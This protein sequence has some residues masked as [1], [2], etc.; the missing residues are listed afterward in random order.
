MLKNAKISMLSL[1]TLLST[2]YRLYSDFKSS[3][4]FPWWTIY[5]KVKMT[6]DTLSSFY[7]TLIK[8]ESDNLIHQKRHNFLSSELRRNFHV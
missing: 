1:F 3:S 7:L 5:I 4:A 6:H 2:R 8:E